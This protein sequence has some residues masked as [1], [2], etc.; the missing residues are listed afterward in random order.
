M[1]GEVFINSKDAQTTWGV[2]FGEDS[3]TNLLTPAPLKDYVT[4]KSALSH[5]KQ[6]L[7]DESHRPKVDERDVQ[8]TFYLRAK[9]LT[10]FLER[11]AN[12]LNELQSKETELRTKYQPGVVYHLNYTSCAQFTQYNGRMAKFV[13]KF[14]EPNPNDRESHD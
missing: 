12:F 3:F 5:G 7:N 1:V 13:L 4:N 2:I 9:N 11:Y 6:V 8:L 10:Q 14:N